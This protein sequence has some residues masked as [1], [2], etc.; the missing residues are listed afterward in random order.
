MRRFDFEALPVA[1]WR[2]IGRHGHSQKFFFLGAWACSNCGNNLARLSEN[3][4]MYLPKGFDI[5]GSRANIRATF[6]SN[7]GKRYH[8]A[9][10]TRHARRRFVGHSERCVCRAYIDWKVLTDE[11]LKSFPITERA[12]LNGI[13]GPET[14][15]YLLEILETPASETR[16]GV[17]PKD[18]PF[19]IECP[20]PGC[21]RVSRVPG[22]MPLER[23]RWLQAYWPDCPALLLWKVPPMALQATTE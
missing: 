14:S 3:G 13:Y 23:L 18:V 8:F 16:L 22:L 17:H 4:C 21:G 12:V 6:H 7:G 20:N 2:D 5:Q 11:S 19:S 15:E 10:S 1:V 9:R